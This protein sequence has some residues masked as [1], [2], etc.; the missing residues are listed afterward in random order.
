MAISA[1][2][3]GAASTCRP[4]PLYG[5][6][7]RHP[8]RYPIDLIDWPLSNAHRIDVTRLGD[9]TQ[10]TFTNLHED[11]GH[12][13]EGLV[14]PID[15]QHC[16]LWGE[17]PWRLSHAGNPQRLRDPTP[18]LIAHYMGLAHGFIAE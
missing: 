9:H 13:L 3:S 15:E 14:Y 5:P 17:D 8:P 18:F 10:G 7:R 11:Q 2:T 4:G 1:R 12:C 16:L 6:R